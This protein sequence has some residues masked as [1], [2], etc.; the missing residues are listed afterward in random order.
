MLPHPELPY[1]AK[2]CVAEG[3]LQVLAVDEAE[4]HRRADVVLHGNVRWRV[5]YDGEGVD[6]DVTAAGSGGTVQ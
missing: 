5:C 6:I 1:K 4:E 2:V 3:G